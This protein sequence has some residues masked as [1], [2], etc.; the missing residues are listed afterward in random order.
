V[1]RLRGEVGGTLVLDAEGIV[2]LS[3]GDPRVVARTKLAHLRSASVVAAATTL[4][5]VLRGGPRD[6]PVDQALRRVTV[7]PITADE[8]R[9]AGGLLGRAKLSGH[10]HALDALVAA[11][12]LAQPRPVVVLTSDKKDMELLTEEPGRPRRERVAVVHV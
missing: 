4:A 2:K 9:A 8:A 7:V 12:A 1:A 10:S 5:E 6:A 3:Q 11:V